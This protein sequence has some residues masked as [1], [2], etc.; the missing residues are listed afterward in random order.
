[1][2]GE[3]ISTKTEI[4]TKD[5]TRTTNVMAKESINGKMGQSFKVSL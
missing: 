3:N 1:M 2:A 5:N 4:F